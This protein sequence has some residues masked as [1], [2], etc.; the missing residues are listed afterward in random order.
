MYFD[1]VTGMQLHTSADIVWVDEEAIIA[2]DFA[3]KDEVDEWVKSPRSKC[4]G[5]VIS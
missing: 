4:F 1:L 2:A 3:G 5:D